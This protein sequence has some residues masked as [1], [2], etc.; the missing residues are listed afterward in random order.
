MRGASD[1]QP[2]QWAAVVDVRG[3]LAETYSLFGYRGVDVPILEH[4]E[5]YRRKAGAN[6]MSQVYSFTDRGGRSVCLRPEFT[7]SIVRFYA[8][9]RSDLP[10]PARLHYSGPAFRYEKPKRGTYRQFTESG[11]ELLG[12]NGP[13]ADAEI[14]QLVVA[15]LEK[16]GI[17]RFD[18][19]LGHLGIL[20]EFLSG[21][22]LSER[23]ES[24]LRESLD[25]IQRS[26][27]SI[28]PLRSRLEEAINGSVSEGLAD[29]SRQL[30]EVFERVPDLQPQHLR[31]IIDSV[32]AGLE[33]TPGGGRDRSEV[34]ARLLTKLTRSNEM[35]RIDR[36]LDFI[37]QLAKVV[38]HPEAAL[39]NT[40]RLLE[41]FSLSSEPLDYVEEMFR[42][43]AA[44]GVDTGG[45]TF[46]PALGRGLQYY[47]GIVFEVF[48][49]DAESSFQVCGGGRYDDLVE[50]LTGLPSTPAVGFTFGIERLLMAMDGERPVATAN[51]SDTLVATIKREN[52]QYATKVC[53]LLR[54]A[55]ISAELDLKGLGIAANLAAAD[56]K[57]TPVVVVLGDREAA[58][59]KAS[60]RVIATGEQKTVDLEVLVGEIRAAIGERKA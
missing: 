13:T 10:G 26:D 31:A 52:L 55:G 19:V 48:A 47:T 6:I 57:G 12:V 46:N 60:L 43:L 22:G 53:G 32:V 16:L 28:R 58:S 8:A 20:S 33:M 7:A 41:A 4:T 56:R 34:V 45:F 42:Q 36:A 15:S 51:R 37:E 38:D 23:S 54:S 30:D 29:A 11:V 44:A 14:I 3:S 24:L 21:L 27:S 1:L 17:R 50:I 49:A 40:R 9:T 18:L 5:L 59:G 39:R 2:A 25:S 35:E